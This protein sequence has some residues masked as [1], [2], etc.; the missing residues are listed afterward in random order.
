MALK[1][2][3]WDVHEFL[4]SEER[5]ALFLEAAF[6]DGDPALIG[7]ALG[8]VARARGM[9]RTAKDSGMARE[10]LYRALSGDGRPEFNT[11]VRVLQSFGL[12]L[13]PV[14]IKPTRATGSGASTR[15]RKAS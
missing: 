3:K 10:A 15:V 8:E 6:E 7:A 9:T 12:R 14:P 2:T 1:T 13:A 5:M 4:D 11:I